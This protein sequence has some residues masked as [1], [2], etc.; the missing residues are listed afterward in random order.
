M[1][2]FSEKVR[3]IIQSSGYT[4][5]QIA[6]Q[7]GMG[8][9]SLHKMMSGD[10]VPSKEFMEKFYHYFRMLPAERAELEHLYMIEKIGP[11]HYENRVYIRQIIEDLSGYYSFSSEVQIGSTEENYLS[12][13]ESR[14]FFSTLELIG[15]VLE[16]E[17]RNYEK[18]IMYLNLPLRSKELSD[19]IYR[20][21]KK[22]DRD[23]KVKQLVMVNQ[24]P[25]KLTD[26]NYNLRIFNRILPLIM[27]F[28]K[29]YEVHTYYSTCDE[30]DSYPFLWPFYI[31]THDYVTMISADVTSS[32]LQK[33]KQIIDKYTKEF[34]KIYENTESMVEYCPNAHIAFQKYASSFYRYGMP[35]YSLENK[36][37]PLVMMNEEI[38][39]QLAGE[40]AQKFPDFYKAF[41]KYCLED[42][43]KDYNKTANSIYTTIQ[44]FPRYGVKSFLD[45]GTVFD[46][47]GI[48]PGAVDKETAT[49]M[50]ETYVENCRKSEMTVNMVLDSKI[51]I[52]E[53]LMIE[54]F[55]HQ[56]VVLFFVLDEQHMSF[57]EIKE[58][59]IC[60]AFSDFLEYI[61]E[62]DMSASTEDTLEYIERM[63]Q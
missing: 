26:A 56:T 46:K 51:K 11:V 19:F 30:K 34:R 10:L 29:R 58:S 49:A 39:D 55:G 2:K 38:F 54:V 41:K 1:T 4:I 61:K 44:L 48:F 17:F 40:A 9:T 63:I 43:N 60:E 42:Y 52:P 3:E 57:L 45:N 47:T 33:N 25:G 59:S 14:D 5:Y 18:P 13:S 6:K 7:S 27:T 15:W 36:P 21:L 35:T 32:Y 12:E 16:Q 24:N 23:F 50:L 8:R 31:I 28:T 22:T 62:S 37:C 53:N 20:F